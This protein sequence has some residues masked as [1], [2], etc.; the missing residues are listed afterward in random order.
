MGN[1]LGNFLA[2]L[3][4]ITYAGVFLLNDMP[5]S[6]A[7]SSVFWGGII[8]SVTGLPF[9]AQETQFP[10][11]ALISLLILGIFQVGV[12]YICLCAG[13]KIT[14]PVT[15]SLVSGIEPVMN[16][17]LVAVF[18]RE[19]VGVFALIGAAVVIC[20]VVGY[21]AIKAKRKY[22]EKE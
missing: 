21:N 12:A 6:D 17:I 13:L 16:P 4:G 20:G 19:R 3:S 8:S 14:P 10:A 5:D 18:Y 1:G 2:L 15:A 7:I 22:S 9:L 11:T